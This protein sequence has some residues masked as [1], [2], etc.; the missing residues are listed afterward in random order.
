QDMSLSATHA[1]RHIAFLGTRTSATGAD[2][3]LPESA[4]AVVKDRYFAGSAHRWVNLQGAPV[5][6]RRTSIDLAWSRDHELPDL[7]QPGLTTPT[8]K[9]LRREW[10]LDDAG[11]LRASVHLHPMDSGSRRMERQ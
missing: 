10:A 11:V 7:T 6:D 1:S 4:L 3:P 5:L 8:G 9:T 2:S